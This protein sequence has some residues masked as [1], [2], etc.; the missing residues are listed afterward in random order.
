[1]IDPNTA[2]NSVT[3]DV[4]VDGHGPDLGVLAP[5][6]YQLDENGDFTDKPVHPGGTTEVWVF[7]INQGDVLANGIKITVKLPAHV[8][9]TETEPAC[10]HVVGDS[11]TTCAYSGV[12]LIPADQ[13]HDPGEPHSF[14]GL[15]VGVGA[16]ALALGGVLFVLARRRRVVTVLPAD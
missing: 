4:T 3:V 6:V 5:D 12:V 16:A 14:A 7:V 11:Q 8:T 1:L 9:F 13:D 15:I 2:N 10:T